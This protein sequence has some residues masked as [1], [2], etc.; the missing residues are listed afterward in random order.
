MSRDLRN[1]LQRARGLG[2]AKDGVGHWWSQRLT[3]IALVVLVLWFVVLV[4]GL[5]G[6]DYQAVRASIARPWNALLMIAFIIA[7][8][9]HAVLGLQVVIED[10]VHTRWLEV[11]SMI[12]IKLL[13]VA[14]VLAGVLAV[15]RIALGS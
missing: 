14:G 12:V 8:F 7:A 10:Y 13:A 15:L 1:P 9:W 6:H 3:A 4:L 11:T 5:L 2:S